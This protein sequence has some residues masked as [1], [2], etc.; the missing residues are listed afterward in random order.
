M[1]SFCYSPTDGLL[2][3]LKSS[4]FS[5]FKRSIV[6][7][8]GKIK[9]PCPAGIPQLATTRTVFALLSQLLKYFKNKV[10]S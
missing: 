7:N 9:K 5:L 6:N 1:S 3:F 2:N 10:I 8:L 4:C